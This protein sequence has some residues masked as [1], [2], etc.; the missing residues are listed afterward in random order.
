MLSDQHAEWVSHGVEVHR[1][2]IDSIRHSIARTYR[3]PQV[4]QRSIKMVKIDEIC[5]VYTED[6]VRGA[7][8]YLTMLGVLATFPNQTFARHPPTKLV[9]H[10]GART[11]DSWVAN[12]QL[13]EDRILTLFILDMAL[14]SMCKASCRYHPRDLPHPLTS[15]RNRCAPHIRST[16]FLPWRCPSPRHRLSGY[17][18]A[19][20]S[21]K[22]VLLGEH[23][24]KVG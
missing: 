13:I 2:E 11:R 3:T 17:V 6:D 21:L 24:F 9:T 23:V 19:V 20:K 10:A 4:V 22:F 16:A 8:W 14:S 18:P 1:R 12:R 15:D 5:S 7:K